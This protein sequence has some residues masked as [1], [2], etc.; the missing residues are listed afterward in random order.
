MKTIK[1]NRNASAT[2][3]SRKKSGSASASA[4]VSATASKSK[5]KSSRKKNE[6]KPITPPAG[7]RKNNVSASARRNKKDIPQD[8]KKKKKMKKKRRDDSDKGTD[9]D[10]P[11]KEIENME[12]KVTGNKK[13]KAEVVK[14]HESDDLDLTPDKKHKAEVVV[15]KEEGDDEENRANEGTDNSGGKEMEGGSL[16]RSDDSESAKRRR[17]NDTTV[18]EIVTRSLTASFTNVGDE[19]VPLEG[20]IMKMHEAV[21][22]IDAL[23][24]IGKEV[25]DNPPHH[26][27]RAALTEAITENSANAPTKLDDQK[28]VDSDITTE[29]TSE[30]DIANTVSAIEKKISASAKVKHFGDDNSHDDVGND[31][32][33]SEDSI[34]SEGIVD[35]EQSSDEDFVEKGGDNSGED[36]DGSYKA[37]AGSGGS[38]DDGSVEQI[39]DDDFAMLT[40]AIVDAETQRMPSNW[41]AGEDSMAPATLYQKGD[42]IIPQSTYQL[43]AHALGTSSQDLVALNEQV[44]PLVQQFSKAMRCNITQAKKKGEELIRLLI[45]HGKKYGSDAMCKSLHF[46]IVALAIRV[47]IGRGGELKNSIESFVKKSQGNNIIDQMVFISVSRVIWD[48]MRKNDQKDIWFGQFLVKNLRG[49]AKV[50]ANEMMLISISTIPSW[51]EILYLQLPYIFKDCKTRSKVEKS[52]W[53]EKKLPKWVGEVFET[54]LKS[55]PLRSTNTSKNAPFDANH[56]LMMAQTPPPKTQTPPPKTQSSITDFSG[57]STSNATSANALI[58]SKEAVMNKK[59]KPTDPS[60]APKRIPPITAASKLPGDTMHTS[61]NATTPAGAAASK[62]KKKGTDHSDSAPKTIPPT[63]AASKPASKLPVTKKRKT[64]SDQPQSDEKKTKLTYPVGPE[65][66]PAS[67]RDKKQAT[68]G[69]GGNDTNYIVG[70]HVIITDLCELQ[71]YGGCRARIRDVQTGTNLKP[72]SYTVKVQDGPMISVCGHEIRLE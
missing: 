66:K 59:Q 65:K 39:G 68:L 24:P 23:A 22:R 44:I 30:K 11:D 56:N 70:R 61:A 58:E 41:E 19:R 15:E 67:K 27:V 7:S 42:T 45:P 26:F 60:A 31:T 40:D 29:S 72:V 69:F 2:S 3:P 36:D 53:L 18:R 63:T 52:I 4:S 46:A 8:E 50:S 57:P 6:S 20:V 1:C 14:E 28:G 62:K 16:E 64:S 32:E 37:G 25:T 21:A 48:V 35:S 10:L 47:L 17:R 38:T 71:E 13:Q 49:K 55:T 5:G 43:V 51:H 12:E 54:G 33:D 34:P 9:G